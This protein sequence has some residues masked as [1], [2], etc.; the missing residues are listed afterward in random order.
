[1]RKSGAAKAAPAAKGRMTDTRT[2]ISSGFIKVIN[3]G[4]WYHLHYG[5]SLIKLSVRVNGN[6]R[7]VCKRISDH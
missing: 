7:V 4:A 5:L 2:R 1:M 3:Q 6:S